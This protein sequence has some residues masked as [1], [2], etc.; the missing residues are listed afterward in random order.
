MHRQEFYACFWLY[1]MHK[2]WVNKYTKNYNEF[3]PLLLWSS[4]TLRCFTA[5]R[6]NISSEEQV[7]FWMYFQPFRIYLHTFQDQEE[8]WQVFFFDIWEYSNSFLPCLLQYID[9]Y[10]LHYSYFY[11]LLRINRVNSPK[12]CLYASQARPPSLLQLSSS[13]SN[14]SLTLRPPVSLL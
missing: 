10:T 3:V 13:S 14:H 7:W 6:L 8:V 12:I 11:L 9:K 1:H 2:V 4:L 5:R